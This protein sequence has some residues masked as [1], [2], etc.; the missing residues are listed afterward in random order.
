[1]YKGSRGRWQ[2]TRQA[3]DKQVGGR[4]L[5]GK[6]MRAG[7][8][9]WVKQLGPCPLHTW[10]SVAWLSITC[11]P[12]CIPFPLLPTASVPIPAPFYSLGPPT[13]LS[14][15]SPPATSTPTPPIHFSSAAYP[16]FAPGDLVH[17]AQLY[18]HLV[19]MVVV[20]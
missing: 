16:C 20:W 9:V 3:V 8:V 17:G 5:V 2:V 1:M 11:S 7:I 4:F 12:D 18:S 14:L 13:P 6:A 10:S 19:A 15:L